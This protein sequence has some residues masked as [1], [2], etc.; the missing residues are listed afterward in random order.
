MKKLLF[1]TCAA[2]ALFLTA[3]V[4]Y[5]YLTLPDVAYLKNRNPRTTALITQREQE[6]R[7]AGRQYRVRQVWVGF[8][9]IPDLLKDTIRVAED[10]SFYEHEG[11]DYE[12]LKEAVKKNIEQGKFAR[13]GSTITQQLAKNL[14]LSTEKSVIRK[15]KEFVL[16]K[17][18][19]Q[20]LSKNRIFH[21]YLN[22]IELGPG[23][24][25]VEAAAEHFFRKNVAQLDLE[26][27]ARLTAVIPRPLVENPTRNSRYLTWRARWILSVL[28]KTGRIGTAKYNQTL[29]RFPR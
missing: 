12:E 17:R 26:E 14:F 6:A 20:E 28:K 11:V 18:L 2:A 19:E 22:V 9:G 5:V 25:G 24:F 29:A 23:I 4:L 7:L 8:E 13:G 21:L 1:L 16:A 27:M 15:L 10:A 3:A